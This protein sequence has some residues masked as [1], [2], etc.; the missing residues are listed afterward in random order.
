MFRWL[1]KL[2]A[3]FGSARQL[4]GADGNG[5]K[6]YIVKLAERTTR[7]VETP[8]R[9]DDYDPDAVPAEWSAWLSHRRAE[10]PT[11][12]EINRNRMITART[13]QRAQELAD[14]E[15]KRRLAAGPSV[16]VEATGHA[17]QPS[18][19]RPVPPK[20]SPFS[21]SG[22]YQPAGWKPGDS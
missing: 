9:E 7:V 17:A 14:A 22:D 6:Y 21:E 2:P 3:A 4:V 15:E 13:L 20:Q 11:D 19:K 16:R 18:S 12:E 1:S 5:N 10:P 8:G